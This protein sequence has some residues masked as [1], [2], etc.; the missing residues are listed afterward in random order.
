[1]I[2]DDRNYHF[3]NQGAV[4]SCTVGRNRWNNYSVVIRARL[5][6]IFVYRTMMSKCEILDPDCRLYRTL[7]IC[8][9]FLVSVTWVYGLWCMPA[10]LMSMWLPAD[11]MIS[12]LLFLFAVDAIHALTTYIGTLPTE[13]KYFQLWDPVGF[14]GTKQQFAYWLPLTG[15]LNKLPFCWKMM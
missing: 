4:S 11:D 6:S 2:I 15:T 7:K 12:I 14:S 8:V 1:M 10:W 3:S 9:S 13:C 5:Q